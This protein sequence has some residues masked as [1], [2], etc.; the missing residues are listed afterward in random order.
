MG[1]DKVFFDPRNQMV[2][3]CTFDHL[4]EQV[5]RNEF[6]YIGSWEIVGERLVNRRQSVSVER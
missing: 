6:M 2:F 4:V 1:V 3:E 5:G